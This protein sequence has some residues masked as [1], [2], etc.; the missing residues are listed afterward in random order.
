M[1]HNKIF[2]FVRIDNP[3]VTKPIKVEF[4]DGTHDYGFF[5]SQNEGINEEN[6]WRFVPNNS[7]IEYRETGS[8]EHT[9]VLDGETILELKLKY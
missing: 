8:N 3:V 9:K 5:T 6:K 1:R 2:Q 7:A 4:I